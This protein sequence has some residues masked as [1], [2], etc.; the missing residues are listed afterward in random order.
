MKKARRFFAFLLIAFMSVLLPAQSVMAAFQD[1]ACDNAG[2]ASG[3]IFNPADVVN[4]G[5]TTTA[6]PVDPNNPCGLVSVDNVF[7]SIG[8]NYILVLNDV[9]SKFFCALQFGMRDMVVAVITLFL[10]IYGSKML[11]GTQEATGGAAILA[12]IKIGMV[13][14][15]V[16]QGTSAVKYL[17]KFFIGFIEQTVAWVFA[18]INCPYLICLNGGTVPE[19]FS[20]V[21][22]KVKGLL[23]GFDDGNGGT[24]LGL[25]N[26]DGELI[27]FFFALAIIAVPLFLLALSLI[28]MTVSVFVKSLVTFMLSITA[29]AFLIS[30]S[31][32]FFSFMLFNSTFNLFDNWLRFLVSYSLQPMIIFA[33]FSLWLTIVGDF[34]GFVGDLAK[35]MT[36]LPNA[37]KDKAAI[38]TLKD[39]LAFC[40]LYYPPD[41]GVTVPLA[42]PFNLNLG[43]PQIECCATLNTITPPPGKGE[44]YIGCDTTAQYTHDFTPDNYLPQYLLEPEA[45]IR[46][47]GFVYYLAYHFVALFAISAAF[48][49]LIEMTPSIAQALSRSQAQ[50]PLGAGFNRGGG[51]S[52]LISTATNATRRKAANATSTLTN[53]LVKMP[54]NR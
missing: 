16:V 41:K 47:E 30:L 23:M 11:I 5:S 32:I 45:V 29:V 38:L 52:D 33:I 3:N 7:T 31:P 39:T 2:N 9:F 15:F 44:P 53:R 26:N 4:T 51:L 48:F 36:V 1:L 14:M 40:P 35:V 21:D 8:C 34:M 27:I 17:Y 24:T 19:A 25:F 18:G 22:A 54:T 42:F 6:G 50:M 20:N 43:G 28:K 13:F 10:A 49:H 37:S 12:I 46:Q